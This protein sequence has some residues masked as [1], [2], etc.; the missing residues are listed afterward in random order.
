VAGI[1]LQDGVFKLAPG[2][3]FVPQDNGTVV[4]AFKSYGSG[5]RHL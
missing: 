2:Y 4:V 1:T 5:E 3:K